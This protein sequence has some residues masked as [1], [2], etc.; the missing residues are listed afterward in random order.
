MWNISYAKT[1]EHIFA[2]FKK[3]LLQQIFGPQKKS[4]KYKQESNKYGKSFTHK[5]KK[6]KK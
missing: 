3:K 1:N 5:I 6:N 2:K 4:G